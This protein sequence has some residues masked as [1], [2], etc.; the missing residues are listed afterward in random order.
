MES[1]T[2]GSD[3][4]AARTSRIV[5]GNASEA[6]FIVHAFRQNWEIAKPFHHAQAY[7]FV[8]K[9]PGRGWETVQ[10]KTVYLD[11]QGNGKQVRAVGVRR[12]MGVHYID[13]D[14]DWLFAAS[15]SDC[16][17]IPWQDIRTKRSV[18]ILDS[19]KYD[20]YLCR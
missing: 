12:R 13:G 7:D 19:T 15:D 8:V 9:M 4:P 2:S 10:V 20:R 17:L 14:Y 5:N 3:V 11:K 6:I 18:L 1:I 16:W